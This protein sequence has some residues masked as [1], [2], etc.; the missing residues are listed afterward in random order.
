[1]TW[2]QEKLE[3]QLATVETVKKNVVV[4]GGLAWHLMSPPHIEN[5]YVHDHSD[6]DLFV[7]PEHFAEVIAVLKEAGF[8][9]WW[10][11]YAT[12]NFVRYGRT[13]DFKGKRVKV[14]LDLFIREVPFR[15]INGFKVVEPAFL[16]TLYSSIHSSGNCVAVKA[17]ATLLRNK[18]DPVGRAE[19][20]NGVGGRG[21]EPLIT[22]GRK[23]LGSRGVGTHED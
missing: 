4:S 13:I 7:I 16:L 20:V 18:I 21:F 8:H 10:T 19:L 17:A 9:R 23:V 22:S 5:K 14:E 15:K 2:K 11:K 12:R 1:M 6:V 3:A